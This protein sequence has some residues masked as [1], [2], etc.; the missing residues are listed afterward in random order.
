MFLLSARRSTFDFMTC[1]PA[2]LVVCVCVRARIDTFYSSSPQL[3]KDQCTESFEKG[4]LRLLN[5][6]DQYRSR[7]VEKNLR[8]NTFNPT[9]FNHL[10]K[11]TLHI[12][13]WIFDGLKAELCTQSKILMKEKDS[14]PFIS[15][16]D[17]LPRVKTF[18]ILHK[19]ITSQPLF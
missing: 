15:F 7:E 13:M 11:L 8:Y 6:R 17:S 9:L 12:G 3:P 1:A 19:Q 18:N 4:I 16:S 14:P 5:Q 10:D 2:S